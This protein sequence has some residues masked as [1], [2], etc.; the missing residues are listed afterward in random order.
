MYTIS[1]LK[2]DSCCLL[3]CYHCALSVISFNVQLVMQS[4]ARHWPEFIKCYITVHS[5]LI[6]IIALQHNIQVIKNIRNVTRHRNGQSVKSRQTRWEW[7]LLISIMHIHDV[8][9][10]Y[11]NRPFLCAW[12]VNIM[13]F[14]ALPP[15]CVD[16]S[17]SYSHVCVPKVYWWMIM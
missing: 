4:H 3:Q 6:I 10:R 13:A 7:Q 8:V 16:E 14:F 9:T 2:S 15:C 5:P 11:N 1:S 17:L 12:H